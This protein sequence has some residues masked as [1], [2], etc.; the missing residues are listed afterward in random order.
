[1]I[2]ET[3]LIYLQDAY[4][5]ELETEVI[6]VV[7]D[8]D[9]NTYV[10][11]DAT[12]F[13]PEGGG[14]PSDTGIIQGKDGRAQMLHARYRGGVVAHRSEIEGSLKAGDT[15]KCMLNWEERHHNMRAHSAGHVLHD[16]LISLPHPANLFPLKGN[17]KKCYVDYSGDALAPELAEALE[18]KCNEIIQADLETHIRTVDLQELK[19]ICRFVPPNLPADKPLRVLW[20]DGYDPMPCGGTH[21]RSTAEIG[22]MKILRVGTKRKVNH[23]KYQIFDRI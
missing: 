13:Y 8:G 22:G 18:E 14:Q 2:Q 12:I 4:Q 6:N 1:M 21:V 7:P 11:L 17:H 23:I 16:A 15:V 9:G 3:E 20:L 19:Q 10:Y 5:R